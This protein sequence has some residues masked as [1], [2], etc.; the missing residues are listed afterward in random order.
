M[1]IDEHRTESEANEPAPLVGRWR[2]VDADI[3][4][5]RYPVE[6]DVSTGTFRGRRGQRQGMIWWDAGIYRFTDPTHLVLSTATD[7]LVT[8]PVRL[9]VDRLEI[10]TPDAGPIVFER[11]TDRPSD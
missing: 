10:D 3:A 9:G 8:Y 11:T 6:L 1:P 7:E 5:D 4:T 2:R